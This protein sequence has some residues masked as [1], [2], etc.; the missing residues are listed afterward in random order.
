M[1]VR[2][3][4]IVG[5]LGIGV[6]LAACNLSQGAGSAANNTPQPVG[7]SIT[8][9]PATPTL[10]PVLEPSPTT[11]PVSTRADFP[12]MFWNVAVSYDP[13]VW[14]LSKSESGSIFTHRQIAGCKMNEGS[15]TT[16]PPATGQ[17]TIGQLQ[18]VVAE[19]VVE[20]QHLDWYIEV[21][22][23]NGPLLLDGSPT[24]IIVEPPQNLAGCL[25]D[26]NMVLATMHVRTP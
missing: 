20:Q 4:N 5:W 24:F 3:R 16:P 7:P 9:V 11:A 8:S 19:T 6:M 14:E 1:T 26:V 22:G 17:V 15:P 21:S 23:P 18:Y 12:M 25:A 13:T 2:F 10:A